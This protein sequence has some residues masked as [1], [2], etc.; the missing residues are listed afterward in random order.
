MQWHH[1]DVV[2]VFVL[3]ASKLWSGQI[4]SGSLAA[5]GS[6]ALPAGIC[7]LWGLFCSQQKAPVV[8]RAW[9]WTTSQIL[10][11]ALSRFL[12]FTEKHRI[13]QD[14]AGPGIALPGAASSCPSP[15]VSISMSTLTAA[16][17]SQAQPSWPERPGKMQMQSQTKMCQKNGAFCAGNGFFS[18][19]FQGKD[20]VGLWSFQPPRAPVWMLWNSCLGVVKVRGKEGAGLKWA[21]FGVL[22]QICCGCAAPGSFPWGRDVSVECLS[23][24]SGAH[25][26]WSGLM[27]SCRWRAASLTARVWGLI[28][29]EMGVQR[30]LWVFTAL[31]GRIWSFQICQVLADTKNSA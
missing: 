5:L 26:W 10:L 17:C 23:S 9:P 22:G 6:Q 24:A 30:V 29:C 2:A 12:V 20:L 15:P 18:T 31:Q 25:F 21:G 1:K 13:I 3:A 11:C 7:S 19:T 14:A 8:P 16:G 4:G 28:Y 27:F